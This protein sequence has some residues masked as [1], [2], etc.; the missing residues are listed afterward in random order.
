MEAASAVHPRE[1]APTEN[2]PTRIIAIDWS[3]SQDDST[4]KKTIW[5]ADW[6]ERT[7]TLTL[8]CGRTRRQAM[9]YVVRA[10]G[11]DP[12]LVVGFDF[13]F[14]F[15][16]DFARRLGCD[17]AEELWKAIGNLGSSWMQGEWPDEFYVVHGRKKPEFFKDGSRQELRATDSLYKAQP[18]FKL[19]VGGVGRASIAGQPLLLTLLDQGFSI[20]PFHETRYPLALEIYPGAYW[21]GLKRKEPDQRRE[22][23]ATPRFSW[24]ADAEVRGKAIASRDAFDAL[25]SVAAMHAGREELAVLQQSTDAVELLEGKI[26]RPQVCV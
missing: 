5:I 2:P 8:E 22:S 20:W 14:S 13:A 6:R 15:P 24:I 12:A 17:K 21:E 18:I 16:A 11:E 25:I 26:W 3:G 9:D 7:R 1:T 19:G 4:Q 10:A 23:L